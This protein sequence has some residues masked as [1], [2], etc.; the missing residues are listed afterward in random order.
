MFIDH[1]AGKGLE[2]KIKRELLKF[3]SSRNKKQLRMENYL[4]IHS[5]KDIKMVDT[6]VKRCS[7]L[8]VTQEL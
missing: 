4:S 5:T 2:A 1:I 3:N 6:H 7:T 8:F